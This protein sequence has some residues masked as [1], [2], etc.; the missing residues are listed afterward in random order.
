MNFSRILGNE[1]R[2][3]VAVSG[4][5]DSLG[6]SVLLAKWR[7]HRL[8]EGKQVPKM[9]GV[10]INHGLRESSSAEANHLKSVFSRGLLKEQFDTFQIESLSLMGLKPGIGKVQNLAREKRYER[11]LCVCSEHGIKYLLLAQ[12]SGDQAE[13]FLMRFFRSSGLLGLTCMDEITPFTVKHPEKAKLCHATLYRPLLGHSKMEIANMCKEYLDLSDIIID[14]SNENQAFD[15]V[16]ARKFLEKHK[17]ALDASSIIDV[18][19]RIKRTMDKLDD[20]VDSLIKKNLVKI[21]QFGLFYLNPAMFNG[22]SDPMA[23]AVIIRC[24]KTFK[25]PFISQHPPS[26]S[27]ARSLYQKFKSIF[28]SPKSGIFGAGT[29]ADLEFRVVKNKSSFYIMVLHEW[30]YKKEHP[31]IE[32]NASTLL[33]DGVFWENHMHIKLHNLLTTL[34]TGECIIRRSEER[35]FKNV[36]KSLFWLKDLR[37]PVVVPRGYRPIFPNLPAYA[38]KREV[39]YTVRDLLASK[40]EH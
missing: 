32:T 26:S 23:E 29:L 20:R 16:R 28:D 27:G 30:S 3:A 13:S 40:P 15:R 18:V 24:I 36:H 11:L 38:M 25:P 9:F 1:R 33:H 14:P 12:H 2:I 31:V 35:D 22:L 17:N 4:G 37:I 39:I 21:S 7:Q 5:P 6:L 19:F 34:P 8:S 10:H